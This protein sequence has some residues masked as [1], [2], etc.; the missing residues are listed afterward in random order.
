MGLTSA[1]AGQHRR[2]DVCN[3]PARPGDGGLILRPRRSGSDESTLDAQS[4]GRR[5]AVLG[6]MLRINDA[7]LEP[8]DE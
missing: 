5:V 1:P 2:W 8:R 7:A 3:L 6:R 4:Q